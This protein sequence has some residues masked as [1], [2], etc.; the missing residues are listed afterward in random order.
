MPSTCQDDH[1]TVNNTRN[2]DLFMYVLYAK[3]HR[4]VIDM[5]HKVALE[6]ASVY[7]CEDLKRLVETHPHEP[8]LYTALFFLLLN[9]HAPFRHWALTT[10]EHGLPHICEAKAVRFLLVLKNTLAPE[11][12]V[13]EVMDVPTFLRNV[14]IEYIR[15]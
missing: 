4:F 11:F 8:T 10:N 12:L 1:D 14:K 6:A 9:L 13:D 2:M 3:D 15:A 7:G 5:V